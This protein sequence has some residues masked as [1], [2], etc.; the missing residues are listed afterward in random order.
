VSDLVRFV[1]EAL[2][3]LYWLIIL[4]WAMSVFRP[5]RPPRWFVTLEWWAERLTE[6]LLAPVRRVLPATGALDLAP[7]VAIIGLWI[8]QQVLGAVF[9]SQ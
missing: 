2:E 5:Q 1:I 9:L 3:A 4:R 6:W 7:I 8:V